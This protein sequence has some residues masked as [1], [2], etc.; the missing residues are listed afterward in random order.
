VLDQFD[1]EP[2]LA[3]LERH[4][5]AYVTVGGYAAVCTGRRGPTRDVDVTPAT[6][7][8]NL[9]RLAA[10]LREV[11]ARIRTDAVPEGLPRNTSGEALVGH[12]MLNLL[13]DR[14]SRSNAVLH[15][16]SVLAN[17]RFSSRTGDAAPA[18]GR[19]CRLQ[20]LAGRALRVVTT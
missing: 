15:G 16:R 14:R 3:V 2:I 19:G 9:D 10:V 12:R 17:L 4:G 6:I 1:A 11:D 7:R 20:R 5:V 13:E 18:A 8:E